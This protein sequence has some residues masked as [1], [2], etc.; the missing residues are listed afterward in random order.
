MAVELDIE[1]NVETSTHYRNC[2]LCEA[3]CGLEIKVADGIVQSVRGDKDDP[4]SNGYICPKAATILDIQGEPDR[5]KRPVK[6]IDGGWEEISWDEALD[7]AADGLVAVQNKHGNDAVA[8]FIGN[9]YGN[10]YGILTHIGHLRG[11][12][13]SRNSASLASIDH[14]SLLFACSQM[15]GHQFLMPVPDFDRTNFFV[16]VGANPLASNGSVMTAPGAR[17]R[18]KALKARGGKLVVVDPRR[19]ETAKVADQHVFLRPAT[20]AAFA[21]AILNTLFDED[22]VNLGALE[23][24]VTGLDDVEAA[25]KPLTPERAEAI[26]GVDPETVRGLARDFAAADKAAWYGRIGTCAQEFGATTQWLFHLINLVTGNLDQPGGFMWNTP[27]VDLVE[28]L[29]F[30]AGAYGEWRT[31]VRGIPSFGGEVPVST[32]AEEMLTEG[33]GQIR[34]FVCIASNPVLSFPNGRKMDEAFED[35]EFM[36][37]LEPYINETSRHADVILP[38]VDA[39][40]RDHYELIFHTL[41]ARNIGRY[42]EPVFPKP[43]GT[44]LDWEIMAALAER[45][46]ERKGLPALQMA[47]PDEMIDGVLQTGTYGAATG[48]PQALTLEKLKAN[49][50]GIDLG[51]LESRLPDILHTL[52]K[53]I[54]CAPPLLMADLDRVETNLVSATPEPGELLLIGRR[55]IRSKNTFMHNYARLVK[56]EN[57][58]VLFMHPDDLA[59]RQLKDGQSVRVGS[60]VGDVTLPVA[61]TDD[62]MPGVVSIP[63]GFGHGREG[64]RL[65]IASQHPGVNVNDLTDDQVIDP[66]TGMAVFNGVPVTVERADEAAS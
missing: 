61:S 35:L 33:K 52:D 44:M 31:R 43:D 14:V 40:H 30:G 37:A 27:A 12:L 13:Q 57:M 10:I 3:I 5:M 28:G 64:V 11:A 18:L 32:F 17:E 1:A 23:G 45:I 53:K 42:T 48:H 7:L 8:D 20:D 39:L 41:A 54:C 55:Y 58:C 51:P 50:H 49:P 38:A 46:A 34:A 29:K 36:V 19:T 66:L 22:L 59:A 60:N 47:R 4:L 21:A 25:L 6:R 56:G 26:T 62:I 9:P 24:M 16:V 65:T 15:Y 2:H 63:H